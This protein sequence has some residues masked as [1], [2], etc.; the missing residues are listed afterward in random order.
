MDTQGFIQNAVTNVQGLGA[1]ATSAL[2]IAG[3]LM[4]AD[5]KVLV[6]ADLVRS[7]RQYRLKSPDGNDVI[8]A[9]IRLLQST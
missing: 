6:R 3:I 4:R 9:L 8:D 2:R 1:L 5:I 7:L